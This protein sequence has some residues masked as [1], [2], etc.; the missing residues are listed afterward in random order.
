MGKVDADDEFCLVLFQ[1]DLLRMKWITMSWYIY[2]DAV[3][4]KVKQLPNTDGLA[5]ILHEPCPFIQL[6]IANLAY[7]LHNHSHTHDRNFHDDFQRGL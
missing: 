1:H 3:A 2:A 6:E 7:K 5:V 4:I